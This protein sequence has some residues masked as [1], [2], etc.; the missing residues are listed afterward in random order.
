[1]S[2]IVVAFIAFCPAVLIL[3]VAARAAR[4]H[5]GATR[6]HQALAE[7]SSRVIAAPQT[8][9]DRCAESHAGLAP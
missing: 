2:W 6:L 3:G 5:I 1:M 9:P 4:E 8:T 7:E